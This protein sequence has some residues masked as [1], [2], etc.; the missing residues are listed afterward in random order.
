MD[1]TTPTIDNT[2]TNSN[3]N[4]DN[5]RID[6]NYLQTAYQDG[7]NDTITQVL[8]Q[9]DTQAQK[10]I[11]DGF[12]PLNFTLG[13]M[14]CFFILYTFN[15]Y[16]QHFWILYILEAFILI[17]AKCKMFYQSKPLSNVFYLLDYCWVMNFIG[18]FA[19]LLLFIVTKDFIS[20]N[21]RKYIFLAAFGTACGPLTLAACVLPNAALVFHDR[22]RMTDFFIH[23]YPPLLFYVLRWE[24]EIVKET[25]PRVF[26][27]DFDVNFWPGGTTT[28]DDSD[29]DGNNCILVNTIVLYLLWYIPYSIWQLCIGLDLPR[30]TRRT[31][32]SNGLPAPTKYDTVFHSLMRKFLCIT[33]GKLLWNRPTD[34]S[35]TQ[36]QTNDFELRDFFVYMTVHFV[37]VTISIVGLA[38]LC[39]LNKY[40]HGVIIWIVLVICTYRGSA[41][42]TYYSTEMYSKVIRKYFSE[43]EN[44]NHDDNYNRYGGNTSGDE[45]NNLDTS[46]V[47]PLT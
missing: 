22:E 25:W 11:R 5:N 28:S 36:I 26:D 4:N 18:V 2:N 3:K 16:P 23:F 27:L 45:S 38:F 19:L 17:P 46:E 21:I 13:V 47:I 43:N 33:G 30:T 31:M 7:K 1:N 8:H 6:Q 10:R 40:V 41:R 15:V 24:R 37:G 39:S 34:V 12:S 20:Q 9:I 32:L 35:M 14:N 42:Y 29:S 44:N